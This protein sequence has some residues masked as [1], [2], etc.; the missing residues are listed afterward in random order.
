SDFQV[1]QVMLPDLIRK[2]ERG[3]ALL[4][5]PFKEHLDRPLA[6]HVADY[7]AVVRSTTRCETHHK[8]AARILNLFMK[9]SKCARLRDVTPDHVTSHLSDL[10]SGP[11]T[12]NMHRRMLVMFI[13]HM[14]E[15][16][17]IERNPI[18]R[19]SVKP[20]KKGKRRERRAM[21]AEEIQKLLQAVRDYPLAMA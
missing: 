15:R 11:T 7:L 6:E 17:R 21:N 18:A 16:G 12:R 9:S 8:E 14:E 3:E 2:R 1:S 4:I 20:A 13:N 10:T 19:K 5:D